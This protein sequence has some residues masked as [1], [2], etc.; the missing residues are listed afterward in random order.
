MAVPPAR[1]L[2]EDVGLEAGDEEDH[3]MGDG[4]A[5]CDEADWFLKRF[6]EPSPLLGKF[7]G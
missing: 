6:K 7:V 3:L 5:A 4:P 1:L 2:F